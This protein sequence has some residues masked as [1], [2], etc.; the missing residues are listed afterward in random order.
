MELCFIPRDIVV[1]GICR[2]HCKLYN[3]IFCL[4]M[5]AG[6]QCGIVFNE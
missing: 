4:E 3:D 1:G 2:Q 6:D 5:V